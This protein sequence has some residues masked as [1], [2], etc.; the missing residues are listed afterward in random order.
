MLYLT[1]NILDISSIFNVSLYAHFD[2]NAKESR[3]YAHF[4]L[5]AKES[6]VKTFRNL[7]GNIS[8]SLFYKKSQNFKLMG[9]YALDYVG[10]GKEKNRHK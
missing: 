2:L 10:N 5:N 6:H 1:T 8:L 7:A 4:D 3:L 9:Y